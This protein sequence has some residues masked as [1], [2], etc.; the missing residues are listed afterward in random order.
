MLY[1]YLTVL[2]VLLVTGFNN[3]FAGDRDTSA[4]HKP[5]LSK[6]RWYQSNT[7]KALAVPVG[8]IALGICEINSHGIYSYEFNDELLETFPNVKG[9]LDDYPRWAPVAMV[10]AL[11]FAG[12]KG[13]NTPVNEAIL[14]FTSN[15][16][17]GFI[18]D[19]LKV[20][21]HSLR[22][23]GSDYLSF[24]SGHTT[25]AFTAAEFLHQE[26]KDKSPWI[27]IAGY[28]IAATVGTMRMLKNHHWMS[29]V[30]A[31]AGVG[32]LSVRLTYVV[33]P[34][35]QNKIFSKKASGLGVAPIYTDGKYGGILSYKF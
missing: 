1:K 2:I 7:F 4:V 34:W 28:T 10:A 18:T 6:V 22:P 25:A 30:L 26:Y 27:S 9:R 24:P 12:V 3:S 14:Y 19:R 21:T 23:D 8:L 31:G 29:D 32:I 16:L 11:Q 5:K 15:A 13:R 17:S 35:I 33:Y 20:N